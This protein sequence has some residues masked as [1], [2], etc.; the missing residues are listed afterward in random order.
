MDG[1]I[2]SLLAADPDRIG[3]ASQPGSLPFGQLA[4][5][6]GRAGDGLLLGE[7]APE[8]GQGLGVSGGLRRCRPDAASCNGR[9]GFVEQPSSEHC[10]GPAMNPVSK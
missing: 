5:P 7:L 8:A 1:F 10:S 3:K 6:S 2:H 4:G 9:P